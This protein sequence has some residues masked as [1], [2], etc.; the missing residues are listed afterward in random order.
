MSIDNFWDEN[1]NRKLKKEYE[2]N[3]K[4]VQA[5]NVSKDRSILFSNKLKSDK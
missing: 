5:L 3:K 1:P 2:F 4:T